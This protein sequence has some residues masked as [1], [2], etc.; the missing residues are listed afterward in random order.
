[1][2]WK[3]CDFATGRVNDPDGRLIK[4]IKDKKL[5]ICVKGIHQ[6]LFGQKED[7][8]VYLLNIKINFL[9]N[10]EDLR[11]HADMFPTKAENVYKACLS[12]IRR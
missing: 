12:G 3:G 10:L 11:V 5:K 1:M 6:K 7:N 2:C 4:N 8:Q 9:D